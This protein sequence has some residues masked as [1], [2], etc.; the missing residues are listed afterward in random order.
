MLAVTQS[1]HSALDDVANVQFPWVSRTLTDRDLTQD[2]ATRGGTSSSAIG[3]IRVQKE[4]DLHW[5]PLMS[6]A[7]VVSPSPSELLMSP[8]WPSTILAPLIHFQHSFGEFSSLLEQF[9]ICNMSAGP[10]GKSQSPSR[11]LKNPSLS[12][13]WIARPLQLLF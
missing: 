10:G 12:G 9:A 7:L 1:R 13:A 2:E 3:A 8:S 4:I 5:V 11:G 6:E